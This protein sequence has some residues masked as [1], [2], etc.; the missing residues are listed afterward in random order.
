MKPRG[1]ALV[2]GGITLYELGSSVIIRFPD[3]KRCQVLN[4]RLTAE[5]ADS[6][7]LETG[8]PSAV[9]ALACR[10]TR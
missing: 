4:R 1:L 6:L 8:R 9:P 2:R 5:T 10:E 3:G 7:I